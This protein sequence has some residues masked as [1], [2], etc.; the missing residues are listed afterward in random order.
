MDENMQGM[1]ASIDSYKDTFKGTLSFIKVSEEGKMNIDFQ[2][3][4]PGFD[5]DLSHSGKGPSDGWAFFT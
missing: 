5:Y 3:L 4:M 1:D 2:I